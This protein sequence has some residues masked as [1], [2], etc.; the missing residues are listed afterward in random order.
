MT[1]TRRA[2]GQMLTWLMSEF[3]GTVVSGSLSMTSLI[4]SSSKEPISL[5]FAMNLLSDSG[6]C[7]HLLRKWLYGRRH[8][9][10][11]GHEGLNCGF[12]WLCWW[13][14]EDTV[15][16]T[17]ASLLDWIES[18]REPIAWEISGFIEAS[19]RDLS[20]VPYFCFTRLGRSL[21]IR[22]SQRSTIPGPRG[23]GIV[24]LPQ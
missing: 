11:S 10:Q 3:S 24:L 20:L 14:F 8:A 17:L 6:R 16:I 18:R 1:C 19:V 15:R 12:G 2:D 22:W 5:A 13:N 9:T 23:K 4:S 7:W 21:L